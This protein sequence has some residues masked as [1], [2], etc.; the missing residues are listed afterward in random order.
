MKKENS[1]YVLLLI[2]LMAFLWGST[3]VF[4]KIALKEVSPISF[5]FLR[6]VFASFIILPFVI[7]N[8]PKK[9]FLKLALLSL[10]GAGNVI[11]FAFGIQYT[12]AISWAIMYVLTPLLTL[13]FSYLFLKQ[14]FKR[15]NAMWVFL[16]F[17]GAFL[18]IFLPVFYWGGFEVGSLLWNML[19]FFAVLCFTT[20]TV[21]SKS[22]QKEFS[23]QTITAGFL[24]MTFVLTGIW[25]LSNL[26][27]FHAEVV[28]MSLYARGSV[29]SVWFLWT[30]IV[31]LL[32]QYI[33][34]KLSSLSGSL[35]TYLQPVASVILA[36]P[37]LWEK[38]TVLFVVGSVLSLFGVWL[39]FRK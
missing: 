2:I 31:Y 30:G 22:L 33:I 6:F 37:L 24:F 9:N 35:F 5:T 19:V 23:P 10:F 15:Y 26:S 16:W 7:R 8:L 36:V 21:W 38:I 17:L 1:I 32:H 20:Y 3:W 28:A 39:S 25:V 29:L 27:V 12:T 34:N 18:I 14:K 11:I 13:L 4:T